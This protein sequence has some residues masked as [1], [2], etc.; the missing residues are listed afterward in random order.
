MA[1]V[2]LL[3]FI[4]GGRE[5]KIFYYDQEVIYDA[6]VGVTNKKMFVITTTDTQNSLQEKICLCLFGIY[7]A[8]GL[9][10][11]T[12]KKAKVCGTR[13]SSLQSVKLFLTH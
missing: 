7:L 2:L 12:T 1:L 8:R 11:T 6:F 10:V 5:S 13:L 4:G 3:F 9:L